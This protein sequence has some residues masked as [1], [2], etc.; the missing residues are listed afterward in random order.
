MRDLRRAATDGPRFRRGTVRTPESVPG[1]SIEVP[2]VSASTFAGTVRA[3]R[4]RPAESAA[5]GFASG[6]E[7]GAFERPDEP[8]WAFHFNG[9]SSPAHP[10]RGFVFLPGFPGACG[11]S[12]RSAT[13]RLERARLA[14]DAR[15]G[16]LGI[17]LGSR[18]PRDARGT[19]LRRLTPKSTWLTLANGTRGG[20]TLAPRACSRRAWVKRH[21]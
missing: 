3:E 18:A 21:G 10:S 4:T 8:V 5:N 7:C 13:S 14:G 11:S 9:P 6:I 20:W 17:V 1:C 15:R 2:E 19:P 16:A 12:G